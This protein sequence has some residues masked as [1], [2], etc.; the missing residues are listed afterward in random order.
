M[1]DLATIATST[2]GYREQFCGQ[3]VLSANKR[4]QAFRV[5]LL[6]I[7]ETYWKTM[8]SKLVLKSLTFWQ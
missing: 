4:S 3:R 1:V 2:E 7:M 8:L 5:H 6:T